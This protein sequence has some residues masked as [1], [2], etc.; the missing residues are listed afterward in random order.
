MIDQ[1]NGE[2]SGETPNDCFLEPAEQIGL[3]RL[4]EPSGSTTSLSHISHRIFGPAP[5]FC[6]ES[7]SFTK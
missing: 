7:V 1:Q 6:L 2:K 5:F 4:I 3:I